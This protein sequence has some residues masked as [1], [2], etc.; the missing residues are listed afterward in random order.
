MPLYNR[1]KVERIAS[2]YLANL[3]VSIEASDYPHKLSSFEQYLVM[4]AIAYS[5]GAEIVVVNNVLDEYS[6]KD[7]L[8]L[9]ETVDFYKGKGVT[10]LFFTHDPK[11]AIEISDRIILLKNG[12]NIKELIKAEFDERY[13]LRILFGADSLKKPDFRHS[14][15]AE[16][17]VHIHLLGENKANQ[18]DIN[19]CSG[20]I[21]G[22]IDS[23]G[24]IISMFYGLFE[25]RKRKNSILIRT[26]DR[27]FSIDNVEK[28]IKQ[29]V[30]IMIENATQETV[31]GNMSISDN[32]TILMMDRV[33]SKFGHIISPKRIEVLL[34][35]FELD[36][37][38]DN[39]SALQ[40]RDTFNKQK[41]LL[42]RWMLYMP[43][44]LICVHPFRNLD[45]YMRNFTMQTL[46]LMARE[47]TTII[48]V[49]DDMSVVSRLCDR[50]FICGEEGVRLD[51]LL[52][53][54]E[55]YEEINKI[56]KYLKN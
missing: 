56:Y 12:Q 24:S 25:S 17:P 40:N 7:T 27:Q 32:L 46:D 37:F 49:G 45:T 42:N 30:G 8:R 26:K 21:V 10:F 36:S 53:D 35:D 52:S 22:L 3:P 20:E 23:R 5:S 43:E 29:G 6:E 33:S 31:F 47:G 44:I 54:G 4:I 50:I 51:R 1:K 16:Y 34:K 14:S 9:K 39:E 11:C 19:T 15:K 41:L 18:I 48:I 55:S 13:I 2:A 28:A 38:C